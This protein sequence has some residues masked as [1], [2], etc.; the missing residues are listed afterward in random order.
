MELSEGKKTI[1]NKETKT[2]CIVVDGKCNR[3][4]KK[5]IKKE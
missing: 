3:G 4:K 5:K 1:N 2:D